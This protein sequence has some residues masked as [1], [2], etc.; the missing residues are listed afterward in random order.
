M[1][2]V[3]Q[4]KF[5]PESNQLDKK[6]QSLGDQTS[7]TSENALRHNLG[8]N[9]SESKLSKYDIQLNRIVILKK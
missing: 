9:G 7:L 5:F 3:L 8:V 1:D 2:I 6:V 4:G